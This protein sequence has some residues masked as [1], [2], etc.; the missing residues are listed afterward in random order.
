MAGKSVAVVSSAWSSFVEADAQA[1]AVEYEVVRVDWRNRRSYPRLKAAVR[2]ADAVLS[3]FAGD[4]AVA[5]AFLAHRAG[6][7]A[8]LVS[9]G[10]DVANMPEI[11]YGAM[12]GS[13]KSRLATRWSLRLSDLVLA[14]SEFSKQ[15][16]NRI[17]TPRRVEVLPLG[18]DVQRFSPAGNKERVVATVGFISRTNLRR[19]GHITFVEAARLVPRAQFVLAGEPQNGAVE[20]L[21][22]NAPAN[23]LITGRLTDPD[24]LALY[25][26]AKVYVQVSAHEGFGLA[27]AEAMS[28]EC[29][30]VVTRRGSLPE[31]VG[32]AGR[33]VA[34]E[35]PV[36][37]AEAIHEVL[38]LL[39]TAGAAARLRVVERFTNQQRSVRLVRLMESMMAKERE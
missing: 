30:P 20:I 35:D 21:R 26:R 28:T 29:V 23:L 5:S 6:R 22:K 8:I 37:T 11:R 15:E 19:K 13:V 9:G 4:H 12:A 17:H 25:R 33:Y 14:L 32:G 7:P 34:F 10:A 27:V 31:V 24:L 3:W 16:I 36:A 1:L 18:V 39:P 38:D 2:T